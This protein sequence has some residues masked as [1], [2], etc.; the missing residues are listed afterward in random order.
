MKGTV[1]DRAAAQMKKACP[2]K[3]EAA[4]FA[5]DKKQGSDSFMHI[6]SFR[7]RMVSLA[8]TTCTSSLVPNRC[9]PLNINAFLLNATAVSLKLE[10]D[11]EIRI[12]S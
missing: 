3:G 9:Q 4:M 12:A 10:G 6:R 5:L 7:L 2:R 11:F 8:F 1:L